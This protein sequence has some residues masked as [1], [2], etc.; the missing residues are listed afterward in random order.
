MVQVDGVRAKAVIQSETGSTK[1]ELN[2]R[3][4][5]RT[6]GLERGNRG[7]QPRST[8]SQK[9]DPGGGASSSEEE[10]ASPALPTAEEL[11]QSFLQSEPATEKAEL[12]SAIAKSKRLDESMISEDGEDE[13]Q[14][15][16][17]AAL[18]L[19]VFVADFIKGVTD[20]FSAMISDLEVQTTL[21]LNTSS[22][23][24]PPEEPSLPSN[25]E[26]ITL[27][28]NIF[29]INIAPVSDGGQKEEDGY[30]TLPEQAKTRDPRN[31]RNRHVSIRGMQFSTLPNSALSLI[32]SQT[33]TLGPP[34]PTLTHASA[35]SQGSTK[36][37]SK[38]KETLEAVPAVRSMTPSLPTHGSNQQQDIRSSLISNSSRSLSPSEASSQILDDNARSFH[39]QAESDW[40]G[41]RYKEF[42]GRGDSIMNDIENDTPLGLNDDSQVLSASDRFNFRQVGDHRFQLDDSEDN[43]AGSLSGL[44]NPATKSKE[45]SNLLLNL[46]QSGVDNVQHALSSDHNP[47]PSQSISPGADLDRL[48]QEDLSESKVFTHQDAESLYF[49]AMSAG[50][51]Q[52]NPNRAIPGGWSSDDSDSPQSPEVTT[53]VFYDSNPPQRSDSSE[54]H[55][56]PIIRSEPGSLVDEHSRETNV[57][58]PLVPDPEDED[59]PPR[60]LYVSEIVE[61]SPERNSTPTPPDQRSPSKEAAQ[62]T[63]KTSSSERDGSQS[64][65]GTIDTTVMPFLFVDSVN[66]YFPTA[67]I[68]A[69]EASETGELPQGNQLLPGAFSTYQSTYSSSA[70]SRRTSSTVSELPTQSANDKID[71]TSKAVFVHIENAIF[72][73]DIVF[74]RLL[75]VVSQHMSSLESSRTAKVHKASAQPGTEPLS[76][77]KAMILHLDKFSLKFLQ[78]MRLQPNAACRNNEPTIET[79]NTKLSDVLLQTELQKLFF[80]Q[81]QNSNSLTEIWIEKF[82]FGFPDESIVSFDSSLKMRESV[83][84]VLT[85]AGQDVSFNLKKPLNRPTEIEVMTAPLYL[86]LNLARLDEAISWFGGLSSVLDLGSSMMSTVT[87]TEAKPTKAAASK[88]RGVHFES[89]PAKIPSGA[90]ESTPETKIN[91]RIGGLA[92]DLISKTSSLTLEGS[93]L[94]LVARADAIRVQIDRLI[95]NGPIIR[96]FRDDSAITTQIDTFKL[97]YLSLPRENDLTRLLS[98]LS[99]SHDRDAPDD[100]VLIDTLLRQRRKGGLLRLN[101][102]TLSSSVSKFH[103]LEHFQTI[104]EELNQL[105]TVTKY[106]PEDDRPGLL[107]LALFEN[108]KIDVEVNA[109]FGVATIASKNT[110]VAFVTLPSLLLLGIDSVN[111]RHQDLELVG[112]A[113]PIISKV[114]NAS[115]REDHP[116]IMV[117]LIGEEMEPTLKIKLHDLRLEYYVSTIMAAMG[118]SEMASGEVIVTEMVNSIA[119]LRPPPSPPK[120][121]LSSG[122]NTSNGKKPLELDVNIKD[123]TIGLNP[124][125]SSAKGLIVLSKSRISSSLPTSENPDLDAQVDLAKVTIMLI[126]DTSN[127]LKREDVN[128]PNIV[129]SLGNKPSQL[130]LLSSIGYVSIG[131]I[132]SAKIFAKT[133][134]SGDAET[135]LDVEVH[136]DLFVL[137]TCADSTQTLQV[138]LNGLSP[139]TP[140]NKGLKYRTEVMPIENMLA[141]FSGEAFPTDVQNEDDTD[142][143]VGNDDDDHGT[144]ALS[145]DEE[146]DA[147]PD[148]G[149]DDSFYEQEVR[150]VIQS[151]QSSA[152]LSGDL[153]T[154]GAPPTS[155]AISEKPDLGSFQEQYDVSE[156][157]HFDENHFGKE[158]NIGGRAHRWNSEKNTYDL[159]TDSRIRGSPLRVRL[160]DA[161]LIWNLFDGY[162]WQCT[163]STISHA[164]DEIEAKAA[165]KLATRREKRKALVEEDE[166]ES[167]IGD[168]LFNSI[169]IG[170]PANA[171]PRDLPRR[172]NGDLNDATSETGSYATTTTMTAS[173]SRQGSTPVRKKR[174]RLQRSKYHKLTFELTGVSADLIVLPPDTGETQ[175]SLDIRVADFEI[176]DHVPTSTWRKFATY[177]HDAG[178]RESGSS[179]VHIEMLTVKP[180]PDLL[181]SEIVLKASI[182][183]LRLHVD[184][185]ALDFMTRFFEFKDTSHPSTSTPTASTATTSTKPPAL[186]SQPFL[187]RAEVGPIRIKLDFKPKRVSYSALRSGHTTEFMH[188]FVLDGADMVLRRTILYGV[189]GF[190]TLGRSLNDIWMPDV[191]RNQLPGVLAGLAPVRSL[192]NV[193]AGVRDLVVVPMR[194]YKK[195]GRLV[196][197]VQKGVV[198]FAKNTSTELARLGAKIAVGTGNILQ[199]AETLLAPD[200]TNTSPGSP[201]SYSPSPTGAPLGESPP[202]P[203][204]LISPYAD[205]PLTVAAGL[206]GA[207]RHLERDL[208]LAKDAIVAI[209]AEVRESESAAGAARAVLRS[210]PTVVLRP[211]MGVSKAVAQTMMGVGNQ[212]DKGPSA[213]ASGGDSAGERRVRRGG[214]GWEEVSFD[215][216]FFSFWRFGY[217][218]VRK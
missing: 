107:I 115:A 199:G 72:L 132:S 131:D 193:G 186:D 174:L 157:L 140:P 36:T 135:H 86:R 84:D 16:F 4:R 173:P 46:A 48:T 108:F 163:R 138:V 113:S 29:S 194:E 147:P 136:D 2:K 217:G 25:W 198:G 11:A 45:R 134:K 119:N 169:Y 218:Y 10:G 155:S 189:R 32:K 35:R 82:V 23:G 151:T 200:E 145:D 44:T 96:G 180:D 206:R 158:T 129:S 34:S 61:R 164:V 192:V 179:M 109:K 111:V 78:T 64:E 202:S 126:D 31:S 122:S 40:M 15:G 56:T 141:S 137:E 18:S 191:K 98:L 146:N 181:A 28:L 1:S 8:Q 77:P 19:P 144:V 215:F 24:A 97:E 171:D 67:E 185:D 95:F 53:D 201:S 182:L 175:S 114:S 153:S 52:M 154:F 172:I 123:S 166:D 85:P 118:I 176:F 33:S 58:T 178:E 87:I 208:L 7:N 73:T 90:A 89:Q 65:P 156:S 3:R 63:Q 216:L 120:S 210:A 161:H 14:A 165:E 127:I 79:F 74:I 57:V 170:I 214:R 209:P 121:L 93:A 37:S 21:R 104:A 22:L 88:T 116:T 39:S 27:C 167:V 212:I 187:Q 71:P 112:R 148:F 184:Q 203:K 94:K 168:F 124:K 12:R 100:D 106:L 17:G 76:K 75:I 62:E 26:E 105:S 142:Y 152:L 68:K 162:D 207:Y 99:P 9:H 42:E 54:A 5:D 49:S 43:I 204:P 183:P 195:D 30:V 60:S 101:V 139:P 190:E 6:V 205:Q 188:F 92:V 59:S 133:T 143:S 69:P 66:V 125:G 91:V 20:R 177:M 103:E 130:Q 196:R 128:D 160:R 81:L 41:S 38:H 102:S 80:S 213:G 50:S 117:K 159:S 55:E 47:N 211:A 70:P 197:A 83:R 51:S 149:L 13:E 150:S 110:E